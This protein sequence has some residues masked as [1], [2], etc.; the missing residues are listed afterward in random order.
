MKATLIIGSPHSNGSCAC[1]IDSLIEGLR[2]GGVDTVRYCVGEAELRY[3]LGCKQCYQ[4]GQCPQQDDVSTIVT[5]LL[6]SDIAV[7]AAPSYWAGVPAQLKTLFDRTTPYGNTNPRRPMTS[8]PG[9][10]G[11]AIAVRAGKS[12]G[13]NEM[14]LNEISHYL[15]HLEIETA[16]RFS[17][18]NTDTKSDLL[19]QH[20]AAIEQLHALGRKLATGH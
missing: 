13:E 3:C 9:A 2:E 16:F 17:V 20:Q 1:L 6:T 8:K 12:E 5:H 15:G 19:R 11:I 10:I 7:I 4:T 18:C 14:L